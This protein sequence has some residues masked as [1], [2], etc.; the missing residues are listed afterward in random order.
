MNPKVSAVVAVYNGEKYLHECIASLLRQ[1]LRDIE[2]ILVD[3][4]STDGSRAIL[5]SYRSEGRVKLVF[6][7]EN[8]GLSAARNSGM[9]VASGRFVGFVDADD[10]VHE[11][12]F[13]EMFAAAD[14]A[15]AEIVQAGFVRV[16]P[17]G[18]VLQRR[19]SP[20][21]WCSGSFV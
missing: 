11:A 3:D 19:S 18:V 21:E 14:L 5:E 4:G 16:D 17:E 7:P 9:D 20:V 6:R 13:E 2:F 1:T 8:G 12:M 10:Y 15:E